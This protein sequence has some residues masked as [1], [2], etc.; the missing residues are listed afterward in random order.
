MCDYDDDDRVIE[1]DFESLDESDIDDGIE[2]TATIDLN[3][4]V[5]TN[6]ESS[7]YW[8]K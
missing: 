3:D 6:C 4:I 5:K 7:P 1:G 2:D 8:S